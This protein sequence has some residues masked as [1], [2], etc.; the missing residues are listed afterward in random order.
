M[1]AIR[2]FA[3]LGA[4]A[5]VLM[6]CVTTTAQ[7]LQRDAEIAQIGNQLDQQLDAEPALEPLRKK[8]RSKGQSVSLEQLTNPEVAT[9]P[10]QAALAVYHSIMSEYQL[11]YINIVRRYN[12]QYANIFE[13]HRAAFTSLVVDLYTQIGRAHV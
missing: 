12:P 8:L 1:F 13:L 5:I 3:L 2:K 11:K 10:D 9:A 7:N 6:G 4:M